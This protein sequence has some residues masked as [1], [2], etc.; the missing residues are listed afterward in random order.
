MIDH[1]EEKKN[2]EDDEGND[3]GEENSPLSESVK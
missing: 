1:E 2:E 3:V